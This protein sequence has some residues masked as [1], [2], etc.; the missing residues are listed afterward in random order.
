MQM[1]DKEHGRVAVPVDMDDS[2]YYQILSDYVGLPL[3]IPAD[4]DLK[5]PAHNMQKEYEKVQN[6][7]DPGAP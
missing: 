6:A 1:A 3:G 4:A 5:R 7:P 2:Y